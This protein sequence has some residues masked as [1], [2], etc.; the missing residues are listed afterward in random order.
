MHAIHTKFPSLKCVGLCHEVASLL[1]HL[2]TLLD[3]P[4]DNLSIQA[5]G[6]NHFSVLVEAKYKDSGK[7]AYPDIKQKGAAYFQKAPSTFGYVGERALFQEILK[8][9]DALPITTDSHF[10]E[11]V[12]WAASVVDHRGILEFYRSYK[13]EMHS[14]REDARSRVAEGT[15]V[16]EYW[17]I[18]QIIEGIVSDSG[19]YE[20][21]VNISN[22]GFIEFLPR[23][24]IVE[25]P[26]TIDRNGIHGIKLNSYPK[27]FAGL[28]MGQVAINELTTD[29]VLSSSKKAVMQALLVE[30]VV[31]NVRAAE[32]ML[33]TMISLQEKHLG[34]LK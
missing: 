33:E 1:E 14:N 24:Q 13:S 6:F 28:L 23:N 30:P 11:Y 2:P 17:R 32:D 21:A 31:D 15:P 27:P 25:V 7:D 20:L 12:P 29:A 22:D 3:T 19:H 4:V 26:A 8:R 16:E 34:Y 10:G 18:S 5:G 9:F